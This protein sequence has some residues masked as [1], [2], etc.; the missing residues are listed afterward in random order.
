MHATTRAIHPDRPIIRSLSGFAF[1]ALVLMCWQNPAPARAATKSDSGDRELLAWARQNLHEVAVASD[2][3]RSDLEPLRRMIGDATVV[4]FGEGLHGSAE[5]LEFRN[6]LFRFLVE[7]MGFTAI[8]I[9]SG[10]TASYVINEYVL[11]GP[12]DAQAIAARGITSGLGGYPQQASLMRWM[13]EYNADPGHAR[14]IEF[15]GMDVPGSPAEPDSALEIAL[16]YLDAVD[17]AASIALR[18]RIRP[19]LPM[20]KID[21]FADDPGQYSHL[22]QPRRDEVTAAVA[23]M[24]VLFKMKEGA[25]IA[26]TSDRGYQL[27]YRSAVAAGQADEYLRQIPVG[28]TPKHG[29]Q[30]SIGTVAVA[31]RAK[32]D[33]VDWIME[34][35]GADG[36]LLVFAHL[37]HVATAPVSVRL[38]EQAAIHL[39]PMLGTYLERRYGPQLVTMGHLFALDASSCK[40]K[41]APASSSSLEGLLAALNTQ[42]LVLDLRTAPPD[43]ALRL[44]PLHDLYRGSA[45]RPLAQ[46]RRGS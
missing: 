28:W 23:D 17:P 46:C 4:S 5:P 15:Y 19:M 40:D 24:L 31:D 26:A 45:S 36:K 25:Y 41:R 16:R 12:G 7:E 38:P 37:G 35:Q 20:L 42:A 9:E 21:R 34:Q 32:A 13:R 33:N 3:Q 18:N 6:R 29:P 2:A 43:V 10:I 8:A 39:P 27:A 11:G 22:S 1:V 14:K 30:S 44:Q